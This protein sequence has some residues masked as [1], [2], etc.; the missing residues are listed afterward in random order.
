M[1]KGVQQNPKYHSEGDVYHHTLLVLENAPAGVENQIAALLHD[2]GKPATSELIE[3]EIKSHSHA[4]VGAEISEAIMRRLKFENPVIDKVKSMVKNHMRPHE[5]GR[6]KEIGSKGIRR[7]I[8]DVGDEMVNSILDLAHA[9]QLGR[10]PPQSTTPD[11]RKKI[12][13]VRQKAKVTK[14]PILNGQ[15]IMDLLGIP[16]GPA[17]GEAQKKLLEIEDDYFEKGLEF[18]K[19]IARQELLKKRP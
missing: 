11:L 13:E 3:D 10:L 16:T 5:L 18:T 17:V 1:L 9:D 12:E 19:D 2:V 7:F 4:Q 15:E 6:K 14:K 8:R